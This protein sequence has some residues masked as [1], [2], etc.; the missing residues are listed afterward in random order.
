[1][2][3]TRLLLLS[4]AALFVLGAGLP[5]TANAQ[6]LD[7][8]LWRLGNPRAI[9]LWDGTTVPADELA[10]ERF[11]MLMVDLG[12][13][14]HPTPGHPANTPGRAGAAFELG[15]RVAQI[16]PDAS[17]ANDS[18][19]PGNSGCN[20]WVT[21]GNNPELP[22]DG[23]K[24]V[25][26]RL[27]MPT[28]QARKG[29]PFSFELTG[30]AQYLAGSSN[31]VLTG[32]LRW[33]LNEGFDFLPDLSVGTQVTRLIGA[34]DFGLTTASADV[35]VGKWFG[36][37][38]SLSL[39]PY[40]GWQRIWVSGVSGVIDFDPANE[41]PSDPTR[42]DTVFADVTMP[43]NIFDRVVF[44]MRVRSYVGQILLEGSYTPMFLG[45]DPTL[46]F[47]VQ[48]GLDF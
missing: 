6:R 8:E 3:R 16:H 33:A 17:L 29:L 36:I 20:I 1:M 28:L 47:L 45:M 46:N 27:L 34:R 19:P 12:L 11:R 5:G 14:T 30:K 41:N 31:C 40:L 13:A 23:R 48:A 24:A 42:D 38:G 15:L 9:T 10:D 22:R 2:H 44:G 18:C 32:G 21:R 35:L 4:A 26:S 25:P 7:L 37:A 43:E 39:A